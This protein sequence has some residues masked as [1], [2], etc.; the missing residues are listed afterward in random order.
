MG[1]QWSQKSARWE[2][3]ESSEHSEDGAETL[4]TGRNPT[5][6]SCFP[7]AFDYEGAENIDEEILNTSKTDSKR[8]MP[9]DEELKS[10][11]KLAKKRKLLRTQQDPKASRV[12]LLQTMYSKGSARRYKE[13]GSKQSS[14]T[15]LLRE[16]P[17]R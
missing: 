11:Y 8:S 12:N 5:E 7:G 9:V 17:L 3:Q 4:E 14:R 15:M 6:G 13:S 10:D 1:S 2:I 16:T